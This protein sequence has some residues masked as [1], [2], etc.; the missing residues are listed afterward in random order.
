[1]C[2]LCVEIQKQI[3]TIKEVARA[4]RENVTPDDHL[5]ELMVEIEKNYGLKAV[6]EELSK[7]YDEEFERDYGPTK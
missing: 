6:G 7:I 2:M 4:Y 3:M 5:A 1:M